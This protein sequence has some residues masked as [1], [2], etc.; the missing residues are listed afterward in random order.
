VTRRVGYPDW[1]TAALAHATL[2]DA[3]P[4]GGRGPLAAAAAACLAAPQ[5]P[6]AH[7]DARALGV[8]GVVVVRG[9]AGSAEV[10]ETIDGW[11]LVASPAPTAD[12]ADLAGA[13]VLR[14]ARL[15]EAR[16]LLGAQR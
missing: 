14:A 13:A 3:D 16:Q 6:L 15:A 4:S 2:V 1:D 5:V 8:A 10:H 7:S 11:Q 12:I 9:P